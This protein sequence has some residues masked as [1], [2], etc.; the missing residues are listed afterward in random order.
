ME[1][2]E[3]LVQVYGEK[4]WKSVYEWFKHFREG[5]ET[6]EDEPRSGRPSTS[7]TPEII[8]KV[9]QML[10]QDR[11]QTLRLIAE[12]LSI[13]T[14]TAHTIIHEDLGKQKI[15]SRIVPHK[16][17]DQQKPKRMKTSGDFISMCDQDPLLLENFVMGDETRCYQFNLE[18]KQ[19]LMV[20]CPLTSPQPKKSL[21]K[22]KV[23]HCSSPSL[24]PKASSI[25]NLV[26]QVKPLML[27]FTRQF[28]NRVLRHIWQVRPDLHRTEK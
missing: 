4:L 25:R 15:C 28:L 27:H 21:Q 9:Q 17:T 13:S 8:E 24:T 6:T 1:I 11:Q 7:R 26:L 3:M 10:A 20:W 14:D 16:P 2:H 18:S 5:K 23:K 12:E 22:S 19:L